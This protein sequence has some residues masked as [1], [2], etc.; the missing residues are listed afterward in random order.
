MTDILRKTKDGF[1]NACIVGSCPEIKRADGRILIRNSQKPDVV[2][3]FS[4]QEY[5]ELKTAI[6]SKIF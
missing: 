5:E 2:V 1:T 6:E 3:E 4:E